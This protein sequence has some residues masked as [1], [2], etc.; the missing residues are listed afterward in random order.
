MLAQELRDQLKQ[1]FVVENRPGA[2]TQTAAAAVAKTPPDGYTLLMGSSTTLATNVSIYK[3]LPYDPINDFAPVAL[4]GS[5]YFLLVA[6]PSVPAKTLPELIAYIKSQPPGSLSYGTSG[7]GTPHHLFMELFMKMTGTKMQQVPYRGS[8][9][10]LTD[11]ISGV[12]PLMIVDLTPALPLIADGRI[13]AFGVTAASRVKTAPDIPTI[14][15]AGL[16]GYAAQGWFGVVAR[17]GTPKPIID[18]LNGVST[19]LSQTARR[20]GS[21][22]QYWHSTAHQHAGRI[23]K[24]HSAGYQEMGAGG[25]GR[26]HSADR[27]NVVTPEDRVEFSKHARPRAGAT[28]YLGASPFRCRIGSLG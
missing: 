23:R 28:R 19:S 7:A 14:A 9:P 4:V 24:I 12:I 1:P 27:V 18:T 22:L 20:A 13:R 16:P 15:E 10:A 26:W 11:V 17:A 8:A 25:Q 5:A 2:A 21:A 6:N 3:S